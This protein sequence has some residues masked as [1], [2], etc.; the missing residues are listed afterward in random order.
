[1]S[2]SI[3]RFWQTIPRHQM[4]PVA[5]LV[6]GV[7]TTTPDPTRRTGGYGGVLPVP[8]APT[9]ARATHPDPLLEQQRREARESRGRVLYAPGHAPST[10]K[11]AAAAHAKPPQKT[12]CSIRVGQRLPASSTPTA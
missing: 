12:P 2:D 5:M 7:M 11:A 3:E 9:T 1:M 8:T 6:I 4:V 10:T